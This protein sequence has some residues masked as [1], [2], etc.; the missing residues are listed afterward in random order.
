MCL[1]LSVLVTDGRGTEH[2]V[3]R[4]VEELLDRMVSHIL[5]QRQD[6]LNVVLDEGTWLDDRA[7]D[8]RIAGNRDEIVD[9]A[10][11][12][13]ELSVDWCAQVVGQNAD[14]LTGVGP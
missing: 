13:R 3:G 4:D 1:P 12:L 2:L 10:D 11:Q 7:V 9:L 6:K 14:A 8:V 5:Q